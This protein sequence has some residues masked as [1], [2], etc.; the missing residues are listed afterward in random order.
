MNVVDTFDGA[1]VG[2]L[3]V[4]DTTSTRVDGSGGVEA[5]ETGSRSGDGAGSETHRA[6]GVGDRSV[7]L[8]AGVSR[9][10]TVTVVVEV[11]SLAPTR[12]LVVRSTVGARAVG[13]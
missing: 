1:A 8:V 9:G 10:D 13:V 6:D 2:T 5:F 3:A 4:R 12:P 11:A 7:S